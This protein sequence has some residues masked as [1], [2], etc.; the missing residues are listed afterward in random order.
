MA[1]VE[2]SL[3]LFIEETVNFVV[4]KLLVVNSLEL[5]LMKTLKMS[6]FV[7]FCQYDLSLL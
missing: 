5:V 6:H 2:S 7:H 1:M 4:A 3:L